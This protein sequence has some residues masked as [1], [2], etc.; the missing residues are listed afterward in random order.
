MM[1]DEHVVEV[2]GILVTTPLRTACDLGRL[3]HRD[4]A[5]AA[6][7]SMLGLGVFDNDELVDSSAGFRGYR[8]VRQLRAL[9]PLADGRAQSPPESVLRLRWLDC[10]ELPRPEPQRPVV[11]PP[12]VAGGLYFLDVG[13]DE[14][15][16]AVEYDGI[17][18]H[19]EDRDEHD[20]SRRAWVREHEHWIVDVVGKDNVF[21]KHRDVEQIIRRGVR[22]ARARMH[23]PV[24]I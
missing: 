9:A 19:G 23:S 11:A 17:E 18:F 15:R 14:L 10:A 12:G 5:F 21:G 4:A 2:G 22:S 1:P 20:D 8:H 6:L 7:D 3:L 24:I 13:I 16:F